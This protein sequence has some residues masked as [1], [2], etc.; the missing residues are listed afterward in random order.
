MKIIFFGSDD[1]AMTH[2]KALCSSEH[3]VVAVVTQPDKEK[4]RGLKM[5]ASPIKECSSVKN[6]PVLQPATLSDQKVIKLLK[7]YACDLFVVVAYG[8]IL[9]LEVLSIPYLCAMNVHG[10]LLPLYRGAAPINWAIINGE[11]ETG[12]SVIKMNAQMDAGDIFAQAKIKID[13]KDTAVTLRSKMADLGAG[14]LLKTIG[15][16]EKN[17]YTLAGQDK[18]KVTYAP[19]LT[20]ELGVIDWSKDARF[21]HNLVRGLVPWPGAYTYYNGKILK[22]LE[23]EVV[24]ANNGPMKPGQLIYI[25]KDGFVIRAGHNALLIRRVHLES[26]REMD[27]KSFIAGQRLKEGIQFGN[28]YFA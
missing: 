9:P 21:I 25:D 11:E 12:V 7:E 3:K 22:F 8:K 18:H 15:L 6:I 1:F 4:G 13:L 2:L 10:S 5:V 26:S 24:T 14:L 20:K 17:T 28:V 16:L 23:T 27:A 19:K